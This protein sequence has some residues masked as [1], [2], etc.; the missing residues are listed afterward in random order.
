MVRHE[1]HIMED[2]LP[3]PESDSAPTAEHITETKTFDRVISE[4]E[5]VLVD[6]YADWCG[7]CLFMVSTIDELAAESNNKVVKVDVEKLPQ[8]A[9]RYDVSSIPA[10]IVFDSGEVTERFVGTQEKA[11]LARALE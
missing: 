8:V 5:R 7:P 3:E 4:E 11:T 2:N 10:F 6:F 1:R 9:S